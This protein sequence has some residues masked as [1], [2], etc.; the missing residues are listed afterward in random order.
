[1][2]NDYNN[3]LWQKSVKING[4]NIK[5]KIDTAAIDTI[6]SKNV[7]DKLFLGKPPLVKSN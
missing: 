7:T 5:F 4:V 2:N 1:M 6:V 3:V